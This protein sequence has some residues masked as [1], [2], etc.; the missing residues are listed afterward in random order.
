MTIPEG[1]ALHS[2]L[3]QSN[4]IGPDTRYMVK[5]SFYALLEDAR[6]A[7]GRDIYT[8][9]V[10]DDRR[11]AS[12]LAAMGYLC[13]FDHVG[14]A[15]RLR[16]SAEKRGDFYTCLAQFASL[17][18]AHRK[19]LWGLRNSFTHGYGLVSHHAKTRSYY[20][21]TLDTE[22][23]L[24]QHPDEAW[25]GEFPIGDGHETIVSLRAL[26]DLAESVH[27]RVLEAFQRGELT[28]ACPVDEFEPRYLFSYLA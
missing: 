13:W 14:G 2:Y 21:F 9:E 27:D 3:A 6:G 23:E 1:K 24:V 15:V 28:T 4:E 8:G 19:A 11:S 5:S 12:W 17:P 25:D 22:G 26:G 18:M 10:R 20:V 7:A 16:S